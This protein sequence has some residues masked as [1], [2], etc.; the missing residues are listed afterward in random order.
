ML[1]HI[2]VD[3]NRPPGN[4]TLYNDLVRHG[5][6]HRYWCAIPDAHSVIRSINMSHKQIVQH[7]IDE[8]LPEILIMEEDVMFTAPG[9]FEYFLANKP[10]RFDLYLAGAYGLSDMSKYLES[11]TR[12]IPIAN[13]AGLHCYIIG[14]NYYEKF[15][16]TPSDF[17]I[18][19][20][21]NKGK[22]FV[23]FPFAALQYPGWS[24]NNRKMVNYNESIPKNYLYGQKSL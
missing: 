15:M 13:F 18:D 11:N 12:V 7:A 1:A 16:E 6:E 22:F 2:I 3:P 14:E 23:C 17:H 19:D 20:Q 4:W 24:S 21:P 9:A 10:D 5:I 8:K